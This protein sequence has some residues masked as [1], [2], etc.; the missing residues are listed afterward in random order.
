MYLFDDRTIVK[1]L[2]VYVG[3]LNETQLLNVNW[4]TISWLH[5]VEI[6]HCPNFL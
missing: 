2:N 5:R 6:L 1:M 3:N 4:E